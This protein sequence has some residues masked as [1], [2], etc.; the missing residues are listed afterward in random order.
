ML[1]LRRRFNFTLIREFIMPAYKPVPCPK[2]VPKV[3]KALNKW[4]K[5]VERWG[6]KVNRELERLGNGDP[7][8]VG[9]PPKPPFK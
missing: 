3:C 2:D 6:K 8:P 7:S 5:E 4:A 1:T 9:T